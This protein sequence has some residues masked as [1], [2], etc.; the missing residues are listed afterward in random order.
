MVRSSSM[1]AGV[2]GW[3]YE[4]CDTTTPTS[5]AYEGALGDH[6]QAAEMFRPARANRDTSQD[7]GTELHPLS[8]EVSPVKVLFLVMHGGNLLEPT[9]T[10]VATTGGPHGPSPSSSSS[11]SSKRSDFNTLKSTVASVV[12]SHYQSAADQIAF[13]LVPC[14][15]IAADTLALLA[16]LS[17]Y[18]VCGQVNS[19]SGGGGGGEEEGTHV[20]GVGAGAGAG[21]GGGP[22]AQFV[23]VGAIALF[24][25]TSAHHLDHV[26]LAVSRANAVYHEF[27]A[28]PEGKGF[29]GQVCILADSTGSLLAYDALTRPLSQLLPPDVASPYGSQDSPFTPQGTPTRLPTN[30]SSTSQGGTPVFT[31]DDHP[32]TAE[33]R[34]RTERSRSEVLPPKTSDLSGSDSA[35]STRQAASRGA[36]H[37]SASHGPADPGGSRRTSSVSFFDGGLAQLDFEVSELF[38]LGSPLALV[39]AYRRAFFGEGAVGAGGGGGVAMGRPACHQVYNLFHS[40]D[41][42]AVRLEPLLSDCFKHVQ[43]VN[44]SRYSKF[45]LGDGEPVHLVE[46][47]QNHLKVFT[48]GRRPSTGPG[49]QPSSPSPS[50]SCLQRQH[51]QGSITSLTSGLGDTPAS[52]VANVASRWWG[53]KRL[54]YVLYCPE[55]LHSFPTSALTPLFHS[56]FW[57][58]AD[59][60]AFILRQVI[61]Q[62]VTVEEGAE[63]GVARTMSFKMTRPREKWLK[64]RTTIK[65]RNLQQNHRA[66]DVIVLEDKPQVLQARFMYGSL[67]IVSLSGEK[68]DVHL[69][70]QPPAGDWTQLGTALTDG[71]GKLTFTLP[72]DQC[73]SH[74]MYPVKCVVKGDHTSVDFFLTVLPPKTETVVFSIDGSFTASVSI[75]GTDPKVRA[76]AVDVVRHWQDL[77]YLILYVSA[78]PD[79]QQRKVVSWLA[80]H[81][82]PHGM[83]AFM[84]GLSKDPLRQKLLYLRHLQTDADV[85]F[86]G[87]Y[88]SSKD[89]H[90]YKELGLQPQQ[91]YIVGKASKK[92]L[93]MAQVLTDGYAVH[94][95]SLLDP[96]SRLRP[97]TG[98]ARLFLRK[99]CFRL[100]DNVAEGG[101]KGSVGGGGGAKRSSSSSGPDD[102]AG[103]G[104]Y[105][106]QE[107]GGGGGVE[108]RVSQSDSAEVRPT[109]KKIVA[110]PSSYATV[111]G[112]QE[113]EEGVEGEMEMMTVEVRDSSTQTSSTA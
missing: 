25:S 29:A 84:D 49:G 20:T 107:G 112:G 37:L 61:H 27:L 57:E 75:M 91:I 11:S 55:A 62:E 68:V 106:K 74:G 102:A 34:R 3:G 100:P 1:E 9:G 38:M 90:I 16:S 45:P 64:R 10:T 79:M 2:G 41:P 28:S 48:D 23:P 24:A 5:P 108:A 104:S 7:D 85:H 73:L 80:Q 89:I 54:D 58:S 82:F 95:T 86:V 4:S 36:R 47:V 39:L 14:P 18:S 93:T 66:N 76:G 15:H 21:A 46:T 17:P 13:R 50:P 70:K 92:H 71:H 67:D 78:R 43:P 83:V 87:A 32:T 65:V 59:V 44:V 101:K 56:S 6:V 111:R 97:A 35:A 88:G 69:M 52:L 40:S 22:Q 33:R 96:S 98:N 105:R 81:N 30:P 51:S 103:A 99:T 26:N 77:G 19:S 53:P 8:P 42:V 113:E 60:V 110:V 12:Q 63:R 72:D 109:C 94:L 31:A